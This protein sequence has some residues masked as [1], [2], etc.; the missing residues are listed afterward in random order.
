VTALHLRQIWLVARLQLARVFFSKRSFWV[1]GL[2]FFPAIAFFGHGL[3]TQFTRSSWSGSAVSPAKLAAIHEGD[4]DE[5]VL[6]NLGEPVHENSFDAPRGIFQPGARRRP[7]RGPDAD[8]EPLVPYR[9]LQYFDGERRWTLNF[10]D[11]ALQR[12][13]NRLLIDFEADRS[14]FAAIFQ[15][16][17]LRLAIFF[18]CLGIFINLFRGE[19]LDKTLHFWFLAPM[20]REVLL[21]GKYL[22]GLIAATVIFTTGAVLAYAALLWPQESSQ[23]SAFWTAHGPQHLFWYAASAA[24]ACLGYGS[25]FLACGMLLRNPIVPAIVVLL[26]ENI[27]G[28]LPAIL[29]KLSVLYYVESLAPV[30]PPMDASA[31][32]LIRLLASPAAPPHPALAIAGLVALTAVVL[33]VSARAARKLEINYGTD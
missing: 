10:E 33:W 25:V 14:V 16:F 31:P 3:E 8:S 22:A 1:Y 29:Q 17:Y 11:G 19:M 20:R 15:H 21:A 5:Q 9:S 24:L 6:A 2:A 28:A 27:N 13:E 7:R 26:W 23:M 18:G 32:L 12:I 30:P 4:K